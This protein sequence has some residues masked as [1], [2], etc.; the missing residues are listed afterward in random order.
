[1]RREQ[2]Y[3]HVSHWF[4]LLSPDIIMQITSYWSLYIFIEG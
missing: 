4:N 3:N 2:E 1:M